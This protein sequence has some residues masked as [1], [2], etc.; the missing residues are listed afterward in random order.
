M[1]ENGNY[2]EPNYG[3]T[4]YPDD[5]TP[6]LDIPKSN[7]VLGIEDTDETSTIPSDMIPTGTG[8]IISNHEAKNIAKITSIH[9][10][11]VLFSVVIQINHPRCNAL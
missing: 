11:S 8:D 7:Q 3:D 1:V 5:G 4:P 6:W 2:T 9:R 10:I